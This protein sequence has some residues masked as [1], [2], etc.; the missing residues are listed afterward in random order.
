MTTVGSTTVY[1]GQGRG[2]DSAT[3]LSKLQHEKNLKPAH[4]QA[5]PRQLSLHPVDID[6]ANIDE[7]RPF[8]VRIGKGGVLEA[9]QK[10]DHE[11]QQVSSKI[12]MRVRTSIN[13]FQ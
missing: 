11:L 10:L 6:Q 13:T 9:L 2:S 8:F 3:S 12:R 4:S 7:E 5:A 1:G